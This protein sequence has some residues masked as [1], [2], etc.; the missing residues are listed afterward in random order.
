VDTRKQNDASDGEH[1]PAGAERRKDQSMTT[2]TQRQERK[3]S[4]K[5]GYAFG[6]VAGIVFAL[7]EII[8]A[9]ITANPPLLP[10]R[11][12]ASV[13]MGEEAI[14]F[15]PL[16]TAVVVGTVC[17]VILSALFGT[18]YGVLNSRLPPR[19][20]TNPN[21]QVGIGLAYGAALWFVNFQLIAPLGYP[22]FLDT[23]QIH[24]IVLHAVFFGLPLGIMYGAAERHVRQLGPPATQP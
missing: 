7:A 9:G 21:S 1:A 15:T 22:W 19:A 18:I 20:Q 12:F 13:V 6:I 14:G 4:A 8:T 10:F 24:Q 2:A 5:E 16:G 11:M 23:P 3:R 17:H